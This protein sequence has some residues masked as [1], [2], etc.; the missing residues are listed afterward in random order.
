MRTKKYSIVLILIH[1]IKNTQCYER[2]IFISQYIT[3]TDD[4]NLLT[5]VGRG[6]MKEG[7][8]KLILPPPLQKILV[9]NPLL[10]MH[11]ISKLIIE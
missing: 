9:S 1:V 7:A 11:Q 5:F 6:V 3:K 8:V 2:T 4:I 10:P